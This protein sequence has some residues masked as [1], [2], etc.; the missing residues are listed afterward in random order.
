MDNHLWDA[1]GPRASFKLN[2]SHGVYVLYL[3]KGSRLPGIVPGENGLLYI[4]KAAGKRGFEGRCHFNG[5]T[6]SHSPRRSLAALLIDELSLV[7]KTVNHPD[8]EFKS[9]KLTLASEKAL[10]A[11]MHKNL[12][13]SIEPRDDA[14]LYEQELI[15]A[16]CPPLNLRDC[17]QS[18]QHEQVSKARRKVSQGLRSSS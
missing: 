17:P 7:P 5:A 9:W 13:V 16:H 6:A 4:G 14:A 10:D 3:R 11:W 18:E 2:Q 8:G 1:A 12:L 15:W